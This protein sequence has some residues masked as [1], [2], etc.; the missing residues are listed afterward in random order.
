MRASGWAAGETQ[1][2]GNY[3]QVTQHLSLVIADQTWDSVGRL[4]IV[5]RP[6]RMEIEATL[7]PDAVL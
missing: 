3:L 6:Q 7:C 1:A 4:L 5:S 2:E